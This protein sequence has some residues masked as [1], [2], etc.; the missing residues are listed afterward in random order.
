L[1]SSLIA[2]KFIEMRLIEE[3]KQ[4]YQQ[5]TDDN[6]PTTWHQ[7]IRVPRRSSAPGDSDDEP[8]PYNWHRERT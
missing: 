1:I 5:L 6:Y 3:D 7:V 2:K 4:L 8:P